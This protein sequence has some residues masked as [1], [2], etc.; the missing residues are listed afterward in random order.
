ME[1]KD[2]AG[3]SVILMRHATSD[4]NEALTDTVK[5]DRAAYLQT[6]LASDKKDAT[7]SD[8]G[9]EQV[10]Q[11]REYVRSLGITKV[12]VS[13]M[14]RALQTACELNLGVPIVCVPLLRERITLKNTWAHSRSAL[15]HQFPDNN[16]VFDAL[17]DFWFLRTLGNKELA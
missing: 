4:M 13:P 14:R 3:S 10:R 15:E 7:L 9:Q 2:F 6:A 17:E 12:M 5:G 1:C 8:K 16:I 11:C